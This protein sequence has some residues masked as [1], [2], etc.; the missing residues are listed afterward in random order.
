MYVRLMQQATVAPADLLAQLP[1]MAPGP[2]L[3]AA[4]AALHLPA[5]PNGRVVDVLRAHYRQLA[6]AQAGLLAAL[7][8]VARTTPWYDPAADNPAEPVDRTTRTARAGS[9]EWLDRAQRPSGCRPRPKAR[10][11]RRCAGPRARPAGSFP[12]RR[13]WSSGCPRCTRRWPPG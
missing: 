10:S 2:E 1:G 4:L 8:E 11:P 5:V 3:A 7:L 9:T 13:P 12:G 6:H